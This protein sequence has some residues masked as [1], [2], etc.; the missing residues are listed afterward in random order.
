ML[1]TICFSFVANENPNPIKL[2]KKIKC[3]MP[4]KN[5]NG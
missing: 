4:L 2:K 5:M 3:L 1:Q